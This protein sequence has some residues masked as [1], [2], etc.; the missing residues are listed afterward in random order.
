MSYNVAYIPGWM[1]E[2]LL[3][4]Q[5]GVQNGDDDKKTFSGGL[6]FIVIISEFFNIVL[7]KYIYTPSYWN[8]SLDITYLL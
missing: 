5:P 1:M 7:V 2:L 8:N 3:E 6:K 4:V